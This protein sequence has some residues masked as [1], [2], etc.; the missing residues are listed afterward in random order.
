[1]KEIKFIDVETTGLDPNKHEIIEIAIVPLEDGETFWHSYIKPE[2]IEDASPKA[3]EINGY[4]KNPHLWDNAP[5]LAEVAPTIRSWLLDSLPAGQNIP[6]DMGFIQAALA[7]YDLWRGIS[8][9]K[10][11]VMTLAVEH[12][13]PCGLTLFSLNNICDFLGISNEGAH[14]ALADAIR[15]KQVYKA[16]ARASKVDRFTWWAQNRV[17]GLFHALLDFVG[18]KK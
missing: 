13:A 18:E 10:L 16:L 5:T 15:A 4:A 8:Y 7:K 14:S 17:E 12:L 3:L 2:R 9:H 11:D 1:M 6:F